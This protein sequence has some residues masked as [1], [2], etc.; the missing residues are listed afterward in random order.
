[1]LVVLKDVNG[2]EI[3]A[4][5]SVIVPD[6][7]AGDLWN[8]SHTAT[9]VGTRGGILFTVVDQDDNHWDIEAY[10]LEVI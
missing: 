5:D 8:H 6:P 2:K 7:E 1:M 3:K 10:R 9:V 4:G